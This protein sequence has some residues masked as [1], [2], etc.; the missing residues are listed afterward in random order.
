MQF[1]INYSTQ[2]VELLKKG[3]IE[4]DYFKTPD[5]PWMIAE[6]IVLRPVAVHFN[7][8]AGNGKLNDTDWEQVSGW[9]KKTGTPY[10]NLHLEARL[11]DFPGIPADTTN[12][13]DYEKIY[14]LA[15]ADIQC[16]VKNFGPERVIVENVPYRGV[17]GKV[18]RPIVEPSLICQVIE[19]SG[20]GM[21]FDLSHARIAAHYLGT[22]LEDYI[23]GLPMKQ[24]REMHFTGM[25]WLDGKLT[26][27]V[28]AQANDWEALEWAFTQIKTGQWSM[29]WLLAFEYGGIGEKFAWRSDP[30]MIAEQVPRLFAMTQAS[31]Q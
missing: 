27:H 6:A 26:D 17:Q 11:N 28:E 10:L 1:A 12:P 29:P 14:Q 19:E 13:D 20:C 8:T 18:L 4:L 24:T 9:L 21:L 23:T 25:K 15:I 30:A 5:W 31:S 22:N 2:A 7:L 16:A 3:Q